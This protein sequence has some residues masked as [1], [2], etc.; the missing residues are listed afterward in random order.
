[1][2]DWLLYVPFA[3]GV[4]V[5]ANVIASRGIAENYPNYLAVVA[6]EQC[7]APKGFGIL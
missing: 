4:I 2:T 3:L 1:V 7:N 5:P 6:L